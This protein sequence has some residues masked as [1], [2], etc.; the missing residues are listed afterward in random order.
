MQ[1]L[2]YLF[3][4]SL[5]RALTRTS[6]KH[7]QSS[8]KPIHRILGC[9]SFHPAAAQAAQ[10]AKSFSTIMS[11]SQ[12]FT[13]VEDVPEIVSSLRATFD[14]DHTR[15]KGWRMSQLHALQKLFENESH[16]LRE[17]AS[18]DMSKNPFE[19]DLMDIKPTVREIGDA[20][21]NLDAWMA[22]EAVSTDALNL[23]ASSRVVRD[24]LGVVFIIGAWNYNIPLSFMPLIGAIAAGNTVV[25]KPGDFSVNLCAT[26]ARLVNKY[27]DTSAIRCV[28]GGPEVTT[29]LLAERFDMIFFTGSTRIGKIVAS[30]AAK[31]LTPT[32]LELGGKSP[33]IVDKTCNMSVVAR[34]V[35]WGRCTNSGQTCVSPDYIMVDEQIADQFINE[36]IRTLR[37]FYGKDAQK[38]PWFSRLVNQGAFERISGMI[39][40]DRDSVIFGGKTDAS[41]RFIEPTLMDFG[42]GTHSNY[43]VYM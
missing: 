17:A 15:S 13:Q 43:C 36:L 21:R 26:I 14:S 1:T 3:I 41:E 37:E 4:H 7:T 27:L 2:N 5:P 25:L 18:M 6:T 32:I 19:T 29:A 9:T 31:N 11:E 38:S 30:A 33:C 12:S 42:T 10:A 40:A 23:P 16:T 24:P 28:T 8:S 22:G 35:I 39:E 20:I 34:R